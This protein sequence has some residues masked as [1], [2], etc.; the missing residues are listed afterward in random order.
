MVALGDGGEVVV[1]EGRVRLVSLEARDEGGVDGVGLE[2]VLR[3]PLAEALDEEGADLEELL[4]LDEGGGVDEGGDLALELLGA[5]GGEEEDLDAGVDGLG[6]ELD[7]V[8]DL[9]HVVLVDEGADLDARELVL[10][11]REELG[12][13]ARDLLAL[14]HL[15]VPR[16]P[17]PAHSK[18]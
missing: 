6:E 7:H 17:Q 15:L 10:V 9:D 1:D 2:A 8:E 4:V 11:L 14:L 12:D 3:E 13:L 16:D 5:G 18:L